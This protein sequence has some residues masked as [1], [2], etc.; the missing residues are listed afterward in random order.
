MRTTKQREKA[1]L[2]RV[3]GSLKK[4][5]LIVQTIPGKE[6]VKTSNPGLNERKNKGQA[7]IMGRKHEPRRSRNGVKERTAS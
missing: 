3:L 4:A 7:M 5:S 6:K 1:N 2:Q